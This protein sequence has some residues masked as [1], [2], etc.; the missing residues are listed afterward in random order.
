MRMRVM[1]LWWCHIYVRAR[2]V[3]L[4]WEALDVKLPIWL[5]RHRIAGRK[6]AIP[7]IIRERLAGCNGRMVIMSNTDGSILRDHSQ[8]NVA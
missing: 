3:W 6:A 1:Q 2:G 7:C 5:S 8:T 4:G